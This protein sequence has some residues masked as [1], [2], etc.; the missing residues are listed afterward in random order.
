MNPQLP[1]NA[2]RLLLVCLS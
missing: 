1:A 2:E